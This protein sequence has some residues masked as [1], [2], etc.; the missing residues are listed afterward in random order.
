[1]IP[2][3]DGGHAH[4]TRRP[5]SRRA[6]VIDGYS[7]SSIS[8]SGGL[9]VRYPRSNDGR[10]QRSFHD[11]SAT[12]THRTPSHESFQHLE[13]VPP[14]LDQVNTPGALPYVASP[15][16]VYRESLATPQIHENVSEYMQDPPIIHGASRRFRARRGQPITIGG[17][18]IEVED[19]GRHGHRGHRSHRSR[20][21]STDTYSSEVS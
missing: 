12:H 21:R 5:S 9:P 13:S 6:R 3:S 14:S 10:P 15:S 19:D 17:V 2:P 8:D 16:E 20:S 7:D 11:D 4:I 1:M 18:R